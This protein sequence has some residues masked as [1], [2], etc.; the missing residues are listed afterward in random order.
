MFSAS[1]DER[2]PIIISVRSQ[3]ALPGKR[4]LNNISFTLQVDDHSLPSFHV[5]EA[6]LE[7][8]FWY[9]TI[10]IKYDSHDD[11]TLTL[12]VELSFKTMLRDLFCYVTTWLRP[13]KINYMYCSSRYTV[14]V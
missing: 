14:F 5:N 13:F 3:D 8:L 6:M 4:F 7:H 2:W 1:L 12:Q 9:T 11:A 10:Y